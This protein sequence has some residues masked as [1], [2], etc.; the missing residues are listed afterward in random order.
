MIIT[1]S[2]GNEEHP[3]TFVT[4]KLYVPAVKFGMVTVL[5]FPTM[6]PGVITQLR[7][8]KSDKTMVPV[9]VLQV[10]CVIEVTIGVSGVTGCVF[11]TMFS[12][13][14]EVQPASLVTEKL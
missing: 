14:S 6:F 7:K 8:G 9:A 4:T 3:P 5:V 2:D 13:N 11:I 12:V 10:G 1:A